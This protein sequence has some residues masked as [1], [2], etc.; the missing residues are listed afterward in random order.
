MPRDAA[1]DQDRSRAVRNRSDCDDDRGSGA[2]GSI[3]PDNAQEDFRAYADSYST[4]T[5]EEKIHSGKIADAETVCDAG[6]IGIAEEKI[7]GKSYT[8]GNA[9]AERVAKA[10]KIFAES[11]SRI[12][13]ERVE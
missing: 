3:L 4:K 6:K 8:R 11:F 9:D 10:E 1:N 7:R 2:G 13:S 12:L 5:L